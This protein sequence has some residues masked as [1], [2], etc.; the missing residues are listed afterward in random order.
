MPYSALMVAKYFI[1]KS[2]VYEEDISLMKLTKL[3]YFA[4][5]WCLAFYDKPLIY[6]PIKVKCWGI[7]ITCVEN[8]Y[9]S[10]GT[11]D[12]I[13]D[14]DPNDLQFLYLDREIIA[15]LEKIRE[16]Y[17]KWTA[18]QLANL[19]HIENAPWDQAIKNGDKF[20]SNDI[21]RKYYFKRMSRNVG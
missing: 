14:V 2:N 3:I 21:M 19:T 6:E 10:F 5:G 1:Y 12:I 13:V 20:V 8:E 9:I 11:K 18:F 15:L 4:H 17:G 7:T 16:E